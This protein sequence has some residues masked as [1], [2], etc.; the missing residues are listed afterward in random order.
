MLGC[1]PPSLIAL[2]LLTALL[3]LLP[4]RRLYL[5]GRSQGLVTA[6][7]LLLWG[8]ASMVAWAPGATRFLAPIV[9]IAW[10]APFVVLRTAR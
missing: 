2:V 3:T 6:Y 8:A 7:F 10:L 4:T 1:M 9:L 5:A